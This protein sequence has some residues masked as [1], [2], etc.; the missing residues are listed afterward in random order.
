M[1]LLDLWVAVCEI[2][3]LLTGA[4]A[5]G[6]GVARWQNTNKLTRTREEIDHIKAQLIRR[7]NQ[8]TSL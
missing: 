1:N 7:Q 2:G 5:I 3:I 6:Y 8:S 4:G